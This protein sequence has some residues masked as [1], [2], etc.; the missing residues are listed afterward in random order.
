MNAKSDVSSLSLLVEWPIRGYIAE[1]FLALIT[2]RTNLK[3]TGGKCPFAIWSVVYDNTQSPNAFSSFISFLTPNGAT[4]TALHQQ[5]R[6]A[7]RDRNSSFAVIYQI[8]NE[9]KVLLFVKSEE[10]EQFF[11]PYPSRRLSSHKL[12]KCKY[13]PYPWWWRRDESTSTAVH[14]PPPIH[15]HSFINNH[16]SPH[17]SYSA[18]TTSTFSSA[19]TLLFVGIGVCAFTFS[20]W[21]KWASSYR[22]SPPIL[23]SW[24]ELRCHIKSLIGKLLMLGEGREGKKQN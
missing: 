2:F 20:H 12:P 16:H 24:L 23:N 15:A 3:G 4:N 14:N 11:D 21:L 22:L 5:C 8:G 6:G 18:S 10:T 17:H 1:N 7:K 9:L 19:P 13:I